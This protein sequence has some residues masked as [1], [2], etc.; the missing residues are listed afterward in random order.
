[1][2]GIRETATDTPSCHEPALTIEIPS[3]N[4]FA[5]HI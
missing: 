1:M 3:T 2:Y 4:W 5:Y